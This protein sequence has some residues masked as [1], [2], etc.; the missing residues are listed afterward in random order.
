[1]TTSP[2]AAA[3]NFTP[4]TPAQQ[5]VISNAISFYQNTFIDPITVNIEFRT[6]LSAGGASSAALAYPSYAAYT[7]SLLADGLLYNNTVELTGVANLATGNMAQQIRDTTADCRALLGACAGTLAGVGSVTQNG[8]D[9]IITVGA[10]N[11]GNAAVTEHE[12]DEILGIGGWGTILGDPQIVN[13]KTTI[14]PLDLYRY[15]A[16]GTPSLTTNTMATSYLSVDGGMTSIASFN[17][18]GVGDYGDYT[19]NPCLVQSFQ[20]CANPAAIGANSPE[21]LALQAIGYDLPEPSGL[22]LLATGI[23]AFGLFG[24]RR[25]G[26]TQS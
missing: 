8:L 16:V 9:G 20:V 13:G 10:G 19:T 2:S 24:C 1:L 15:S 11:Y 25:L 26:L 7:A 6:T 14:G 12:I 5:T 3:G 21:G 22:A 18:S 23:G 4:V 17:Q